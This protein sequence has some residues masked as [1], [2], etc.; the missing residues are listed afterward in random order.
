MLWQAA[1]LERLL[2]S[3]L[4]FPEAARRR[5]IGNNKRYYP[6]P[7]R[8]CIPSSLTTTHSWLAFG[9]DVYFGISCRINAD[10]TSLGARSERPE[11]QAAE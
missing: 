11:L 7:C 3:K 1:F 6:A 8:L 2:S 9:E 4:S 10:F 5:I